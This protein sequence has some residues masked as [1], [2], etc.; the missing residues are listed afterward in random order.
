M[1]ANIQKQF[2]FGDFRLEK[3]ANEFI[4][5]IE[6]KNS[7]ILR[8][9]ANNWNEEV[10]YGRLID[11][12]KVTEDELIRSICSTTN[13]LTEGKHV[14]IISDTT[15]LNFELREGK[16][17]L[18]RLGRGNNNGLKV[19]SSIVLDATDGSILGLS[20]IY[21]YLPSDYHEGKVLTRWARNKLSV[22]EK[23]SGRWISSAKASFL[24][25]SQAQMRTLITDREGDFYELFMN[26]INTDLNNHVLI[27]SSN[28]R[29][30]YDNE[31]KLYEHADTLEAKAVYE[32]DLPKTE[33]SIRQS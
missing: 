29:I 30:L 11:N 25:C 16:I 7:L 22:F 24:R 5:A 19:H 28:N 4:N 13:Q 20:D 27:R 3:R 10:A 12:Y 6:G 23:S 18:E 32:V 31:N 14:L 17:D 1:T 2:N 15:D 33:V 9:V 21:S 8:Q 26:V